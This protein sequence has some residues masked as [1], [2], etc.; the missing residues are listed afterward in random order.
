MNVNGRDIGDALDGLYEELHARVRAEANRE[1]VIQGFDGDA[2]SNMRWADDD[3]EVHVEVHENL[4][5][6]AIAHTL[7][8]ALQH[9]RQ[10]LDGYPEV[11][12]P[13][14]RQAARGAGPVRT[15]LREVVMAPEA[16]GRIEHPA[17][18]WSSLSEEMERAL[19]IAVARGK[20]IVEAVN[21]H[22]WGSADACL[23][24]L[25]AAR[26]AAGMQYVAWIVNHETGATI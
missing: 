12:R 8:I 15:M 10:R 23:Q 14:G 24:A 1:L 25:V 19:P 17:E 11:R 16:E 21:E 22:G 4:P 3:D 18:R 20:R 6:H 2:F 5:T 13:H 7:A 9:V 26:Q